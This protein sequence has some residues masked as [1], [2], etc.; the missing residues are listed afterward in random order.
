MSQSYTE[1]IQAAIRTLLSNNQSTLLKMLQTSIS[2]TNGSITRID[3]NGNYI[4]Y[5]NIEHGKDSKWFV[6]TITTKQMDEQPSM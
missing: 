3:E 2:D 6:T 1:E 5:T 4:I